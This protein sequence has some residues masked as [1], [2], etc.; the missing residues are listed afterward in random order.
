MK[1][2]Q[3]KQRN[4]IYKKEQSG[5]STAE[6]HSIENANSLTWSQNRLKIASTKKWWSQNREV[7]IMATKYPCLLYAPSWKLLL[8]K[9]WS[10]HSLFPR[11]TPCF[12]ISTCLLTSPPCLAIRKVSQDS[13][14]QGAKSAPLFGNGM[15]AQICVILGLNSLQAR[16][17]QFHTTSSNIF[18]YSI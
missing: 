13:P 6:K 18:Y 11:N 7:K 8:K 17:Y 9:K 4:G 15:R 14:C 16:Q 12:S 3:S 10:I 2:E 1:V 5:N